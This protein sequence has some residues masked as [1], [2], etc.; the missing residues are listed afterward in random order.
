MKRHACTSSDR[1]QKKAAYTTF[2]TILSCKTTSIV[3]H[4][5]YLEH[6]A[7]LIANDMLVVRMQQYLELDKLSTV[8]HDFFIHANRQIQPLRIRLTKLQQTACHTNSPPS[9]TNRTNLV[10]LIQWTVMPVVVGNA[11]STK[12]FIVME[13]RPAVLAAKFLLL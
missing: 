11:H 2:P 6:I 4:Q 5:S 13:N 3:H 9:Y 8:I 10:V 7:L 1:I 12:L